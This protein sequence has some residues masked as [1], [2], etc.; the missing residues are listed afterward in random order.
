VTQSS[1]SVV[2][3]V[4]LVTKV[5]FPRF[6][7]P[8]GAVVVPIVDF[9]LAF[10]VFVG[11]IL[12]YDVDVNRTAWLAPLFMLLAVVT[13]AGVGLWLSAINVRYRDVI[14]AVPFVIQIW[15]FLS[16]V[17]YPTVA[18]PEKWQWIYALNPMNTVI[19]GFRWSFFGTPSPTN[20]QLALG[21]LVAV[22]VFVSGLAYFQRS[23][24]RFADTI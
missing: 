14:Y 13:A 17:L 24:P 3:N 21:A 4:N 2:A 8:F 22:A 7:L 11:L 19:S 9:L 5:F 20:A 16:P 1:T 15:L 23:E 10:C 6:L 18:L 12:Y